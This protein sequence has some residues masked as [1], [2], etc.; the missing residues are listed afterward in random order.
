MNNFLDF[1]DNDIKAK[2]ILIE[3]MPQNS[4]A[5]KKRIND[6]IDTILAKYVEYQTSLY[7]YMKEK[8]KQFDINQEKDDAEKIKL[9][10]KD[11]EKA[12][13]IMNNSNS[14]LEKMHFD[15]LFFNISH[16]F[17][18]DFDSVNATIDQFIDKFNKAGI[19]LKE[20]DFTYTYFVFEYM[21]EFLQ[22]RKENK[23]NY[24]SLSAT[25]ERIYWVNPEIIDHIYLNFRYIIK[26]NYKYFESYI[27]KK[28]KET[29][30]YF[31]IKTYDDLEQKLKELYL[32][33]EKTD[34]ETIT[35]IINLARNN[36][37]DIN[38]FLAKSKMKTDILSDLLI[39]SNKIN[40]EEFADKIYQTLKKL[41]TNI[42]ECISY[43]ELLPIIEFFKEQY[44]NFVEKSPIEKLEK[45]LTT[46][47]KNISQKRDKISDINKI[48]F[49]GKKGLFKVND[50]KI[51][52]LKLETIKMSK[53]IDELN[54]KHDLIYYGWYIKRTANESIT[55]GDVLKIFY[56]FDYLK[57]ITIK[58]VYG[59]A[60]D[61]SYIEKR[62]SDFDS[63]AINPTFVLIDG[64][65][66]L[67][68]NNFIRN[69][70][71]K[72]RIDDINLNEENL[73][74]D[75]LPEL[76][77]KI[78]FLL[79]SNI[80]EKSPVTAEEIWY[81]LQVEKYAPKDDKNSL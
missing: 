39:D 23:G 52:E 67:K 35:D 24:D 76:L 14:P 11:I 46:S 15:S 5:D 37:I 38:N 21:K 50:K 20:S 59:K 66:L 26:E 33:L 56:N 64:I 18:Y 58:Q 44:V 10:I 57:K 55:I 60:V 62:S 70:M 45:D 51:E 72:Y 48:I 16:Y 79:R 54:K 65:S 1:I 53:E 9:E 34:S 29:I 7:N 3:T 63:F 78:K 49:T 13:T 30:E 2:K 77:G 43:Y 12:M 22:N 25:F 73:K 4:K 32:Q 8:S 61:P 27:N 81:L 36:E 41:E 19:T 47:L 68:E 74:I 28:Q 42:F 40:E 71:N 69:L 75:A 80:I 17:D 31:K 6:K